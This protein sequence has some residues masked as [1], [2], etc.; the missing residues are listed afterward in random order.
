MWESDHEEGWALKNW[1]FQIVML[2][3]TLES[4]LDCKTK[5]INPKGNL[6]WILI[7]RTN[8]KA[9]TPILWP[10]HGKSRF[11]GKDPDAG[12]DWRQKEKEAAED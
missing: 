11:I 2:E 3:R 10:P 12:N 5:P 8:A 1:C 6:P 9:E 7:E 4:S